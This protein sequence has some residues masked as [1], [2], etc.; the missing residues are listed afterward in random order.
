MPRRYHVIVNARSGTALGMDVSPEAL[1]QHF[2]DDLPEADIVIDADVNAPLAERI[3]KAKDSDAEIIVAAGGDGTVT[4]VASAIVDT[5]KTLA[6]MP[7]GTANTLARDLGVPL[8]LK[9]WG[10]AIEAMEPQK[11]D[12]GDVNGRIFL[13]NVVAGLIP[14]I[15]AGREQMRGSNV[16]GARLALARF[17]LRRLFRTRR[18]AVEITDKSGQPQIR[19]VIAVAI[20]NNQFDEGVGRFLARERID[21]GSL[22]VYLLKHLSP[23]DLVRLVFE[24][25]IGNWRQDEAIDVDTVSALTL[26]TRKQTLKV[27]LDGELELLEVPLNFRIRPLALSVLAATPPPPA[28]ADGA[29]VAAEG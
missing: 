29:A 17:V 8:D 27:M 28:P 16:F 21:N 13:H 5:D 2:S 25:L 23:V 1:R 15:V 24:M 11:I 19:R 6:I 3:E 7:L 26:R 14:G 12:V 20:G 4:A 9:L 10:A 18:M 22:G